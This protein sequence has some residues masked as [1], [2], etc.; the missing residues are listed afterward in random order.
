MKGIIRTLAPAILVVLAMPAVAQQLTLPPSGDNQHSIVTQFIGPVSVTVDY[1]SPDVTSP[2]GEDRTGKIWGQL[3]PYGLVNLGFGSCQECP[4]RAGS[5]E[6]TVFTVSHDVQ[7]EGKPLPAGSYGLHM[8]PGE[9]EWTVVFS[10]NS[11]SWGS[12]FYDP[13]EDALRVEVK[14]HES[15]FHEWL[16]YEF[17]DR[18]PDQ[19]VV[20]LKW[21]NLAIPITITVPVIESIYMAELRKELRNAPGFQWQNWSQAAQYAIQNGYEE[22]GLEWAQAAVNTPF[23]GQENFTTLTTL[24]QALEAN[25]RKEEANETLMRAVNHPTAD[26]FGIHA[27]GRQLIAQGKPEKALEVFRINYERFDG[28]WPTHVGM[29]RGLSAV[30]EYERAAEHARQA[31]AQAPDEPNRQ[32]LQKMIETLEKGEGIN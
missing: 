3:V 32:N 18:D 7:I 9:E 29:A 30:G 25:G 20:A 6:N 27:F 11:T 19:A 28:A 1:N 31:L 13:A 21:E 12:F 5:N 4:W 23:V 26:P 2:T 15:E 24:S 22:E 17:I 8:I 14:P 10:S 16:T